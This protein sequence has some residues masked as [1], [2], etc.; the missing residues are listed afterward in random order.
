MELLIIIKAEMT[1]LCM[2][3]VIITHQLWY[4]HSHTLLVPPTPVV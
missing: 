3:L 2:L 1:S 4:G